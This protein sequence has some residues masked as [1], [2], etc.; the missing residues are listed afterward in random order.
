MNPYD[1]NISVYKYNGSGWEPCDYLIR[2]SYVELEMPGEYPL[3][4]IVH[5]Y[6]YKL[7]AIVGGSCIA[8]IVI[9]VFVILM[10]R[11]SRKGKAKK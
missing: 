11:K 3:Y 9:A 8:V 1:K 10:I 5:E 6:D 2:G 7:M 4:C